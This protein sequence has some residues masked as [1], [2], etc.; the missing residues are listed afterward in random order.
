MDEKIRP[1]CKLPI[2]DSLQFYRYKDWKQG[3]ENVCHAN[4]NKKARAVILTSEKIDFKT[5]A[6]RRQRRT[7]HNSLSKK[8]KQ[9]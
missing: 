9:L 3:K 8:I 6:N 1:I 5:K 4:V 2:R 7:L